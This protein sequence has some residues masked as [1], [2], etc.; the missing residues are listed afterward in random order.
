MAVGPSRARSGG[1]E[2]ARGDARSA[3]WG[4]PVLG[5]PLRVP[6]PTPCTSAGLTLQ[7]VGCKWSRALNLQ[8]K[9]PNHP[10]DKLFY[11]KYSDLWV[12]ALPNAHPQ[13]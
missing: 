4:V 8:A 10:A 13:Q 11:H 7:P 3:P 1:C 9:R 12:R 5:S 2:D 6:Q